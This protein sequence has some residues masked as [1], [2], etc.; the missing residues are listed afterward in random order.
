MSKLR[1]SKLG[2]AECPKC[3]QFHP[4]GHSFKNHVKKC[5]GPTPHGKAPAGKHHQLFPDRPNVRKPGV[6][7]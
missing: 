1:Q 5:S 3:H 6:H 7:Y 4:E 2:L